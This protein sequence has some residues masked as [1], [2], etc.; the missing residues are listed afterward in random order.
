MTKDMEHFLIYLLVSVFLLLKVSA[1]VG[2]LVLLGNIFFQGTEFETVE[3]IE[4][5]IYVFHGA[6][7]V[8]SHEDLCMHRNLSIFMAPAMA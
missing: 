2:P 3:N 6:L 7:F 5:A 4:H 1:N 8:G